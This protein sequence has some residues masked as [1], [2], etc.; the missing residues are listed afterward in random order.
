MW[1][2]DRWMINAVL[3][4]RNWQLNIVGSDTHNKAPAFTFLYYCNDVVILSLHTLQ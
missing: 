1:F 2:E 3:L 4:Q